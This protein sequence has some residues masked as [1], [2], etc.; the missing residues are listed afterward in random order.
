MDHAEDL[1]MRLNAYLNSV[2]RHKNMF[3]VD[4]DW[5]VSSVVKLTDDK[6]DQIGYERLQSRLRVQKVSVSSYTAIPVY[7]AR[8]AGLKK[9][10]IVIRSLYQ[11]PAGIC[12]H[13]YLWS[14]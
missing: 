6:M 14:G 2:P 5:L 7:H 8:F 1:S 10:Y 4:G 11:V 9:Q 13:L 12:N 3:V